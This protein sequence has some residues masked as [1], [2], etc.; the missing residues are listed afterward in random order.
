MSKS[1][2]IFRDAV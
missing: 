1:P 2:L